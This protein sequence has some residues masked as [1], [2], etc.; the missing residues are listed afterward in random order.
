MSK[1]SITFCPR[2]GSYSLEQLKSY[3]HCF[4]CLYVRDPKTESV[5]PDWARD[6]YYEISKQF[7]LMFAK[8]TSN[9][10]AS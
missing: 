5:I 1:S 7:D 10:K 2:C 6:Q 9:T 4:Q 8:A 3:A